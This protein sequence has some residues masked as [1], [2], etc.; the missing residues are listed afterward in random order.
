MIYKIYPP[1]P[2]VVAYNS[3]TAF[4]PGTDRTANTL[5]TI[6]PIPAEGICLINSDF[7]AQVIATTEPAN[8]TVLGSIYM[9]NH[10]ITYVFAN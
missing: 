3:K 2:W 7:G 1:L 4:V 5:I 6:S 8:I 9:S 10:S